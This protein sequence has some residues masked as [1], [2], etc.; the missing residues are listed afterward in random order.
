MTQLILNKWYKY[1][2]HSE[3][4]ALQFFEYFYPVVYDRDLGY[5][6]YYAYICKSGKRVLSV[7]ISA[8]TRLSEEDCYSFEPSDKPHLEESLR[9][10]IN[11]FD[12]KAWN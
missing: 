1:T 8:W 4:N 11:D 3:D 6:G 7:E 5:E 10:C 9:E 12:K 2:Y